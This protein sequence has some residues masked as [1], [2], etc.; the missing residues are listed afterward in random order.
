MCMIPM[1]A[2]IGFVGA[3]RMASAMIGGLISEDRGEST[4]AI[5]VLGAIPLFGKAFRS[6]ATLNN[7]T[8][9]VI[10]LT[11]KLIR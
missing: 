7:R 2:K 6:R 1:S 5:P 4:R 10:F 8:E 9:L 3:G 11:P